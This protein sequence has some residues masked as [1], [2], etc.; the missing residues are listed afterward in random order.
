MTRAA[1]VLGLLCIGLVHCGAPSQ[2]PC[3]PGDLA[4]IQ[5]AYSARMLATGCVGAAVDTCEAGPSLKAERIAEE[6]SGGCLK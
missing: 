2:Q 3:S 5:A 1:L 4:A 6:K